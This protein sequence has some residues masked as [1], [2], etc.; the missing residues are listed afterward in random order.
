MRSRQNERELMLREKKR[1][2]R[3][4]IIDIFFILA[5]IGASIFF[6]RSLLEL[7]NIENLLR[8]TVI[9]VTVFINLIMIINLFRSK[10]KK[11]RVKKVFKRILI[12]IMV[13]V[14]I[15]GGFTINK[16]LSKLDNM[17]KK[18]V[19]SSTAL[20]TLSS[21]P[22]SDVSKIR[23]S[24]IG[25]GA[26]KDNTEFYV[27]PME[28]LQ[29]NNLLKRNSLVEYDDYQTAISDLLNKNVDYIF[30]PSNYVEIYSNHD[31]YEDLEEQTKILTTSQ[32]EETK[33]EVGLKGSS[34]DVSE[35][36]TVLL[37]GVDST[38]NGLKNANS[39]NGDSIMLI[40]F[41]PT[42][43]NATMLSI[44]RDS[45]VPISCMSNKENKITHAA[46]HGAKCVIKTV[47]NYF[48]LEIDYY[49]KINFTGLVNLVDALGGVEVDVPYSFCE[50]NSKRKWGKD[51]IYVKKGKQ[52]LNGEQ[53]LALARNRKSN[54]KKCSSKEYTQGVRND[55]VRGQNQQLV[56]Q[57]IINK[58][59]NIDSISDVYKILD[60][61]SN[62]LDT[63]M[64]RDTILSFYN[65]AKDI[66]FSSRDEDSELVS[67]QKLY[68]AGS[69]QIIF[70]ERSKLELYNYIPNTTSKKMI[71]DAMKVNL[72]LK[73]PTPDK[74][75][76]Y[77]IEDP[78]EQTEIGK[79][80]GAP[81]TLYTL[82]PDFTTYTKSRAESWA[83]VNGFNIVWK[84]VVTTK[85]PA[86]KIYDQSYH[87]KKRVDLCDSKTITLTIATRKVATPTTPKV[88]DGGSTGED[89]TTPS[90][91][92]Q[93][94]GT[95]GN[96]S[97]S[98][99]TEGTP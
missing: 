98:S 50:Q 46:S 85:Y 47:E 99:T 45:Y 41:N 11:T 91:P 62:N 10:K 70:D 22:I 26:D 8:Y 48:G 86:G 67:I 34:K 94:G 60:T 76:S 42:T 55:F 84:E 33:E 23:N 1:K 40:T 56:I 78:Y 95:T 30:L 16:V 2:R 59:K 27:L 64:A 83:T 58:A 20:V 4:F 39:F 82:I 74:K 29:K 35:P 53:A 92:S 25:I 97:G 96:E 88:D 75:F 18:T 31:E 93:N 81:T 28:I 77:S 38:A 3:S 17:N 63:N 68:L 14:F 52:T 43:L 19:T 71:I 36:F 15:F 69:D 73:N 9:G 89:T 65:I 87:R 90:T 51:T 12:L 61:I 32:K 79:K 24:K 44:P 21:N 49:A 37:M 13:A 7:K 5:S 54:A 57:G 80:P 66:M 6:I 72:G